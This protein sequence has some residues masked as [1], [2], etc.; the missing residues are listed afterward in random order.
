MVLSPV[1]SRRLVVICGP[2]GVGKT[3]VS[4]EL[5]R[6]IGAE[7]VAADS[8]TVYRRMDIGTAKPTADQQ[9]SVPHHLLD[10]AE[11]DEIFTLA[12][13]RKL[14]M[15]AI[16]QIFARKAIPLLVGG[17]GLYVRAIVDGLTIPSVAPN[18]ELRTELESIERRA[19]GS[20]HARLAHVDPVAATRIHPRNVRRT[21]RALEVYEQ[22][23]HS[24]TVA[25]ARSAPP[26]DVL[27]IGLTMD[28]DALYAQIE[29]RVDEQ[30]AAG[31]VDEVKALLLQGYDRALP[32]LQGLGYKEIIE[33]LDGNEALEEASRR[34]KQHTRQFAKRQYTWFRKDVRIQWVDVGTRL[35]TS[36]AEM[37]LPMVE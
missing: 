9:A 16:G 15:A 8:R 4:L 35:P 17:T 37:L 23:G 6:R 2:T 34:L 11:P 21:I 27:Q 18:W 19:P 3:G 31:L 25:Q 29:R 1:A 33:Y 7:I 12:D 22:T 20:L 10:V 32:S 26:F 13:Y 30:L 24:I 14:A 36:V 28:R 5:A